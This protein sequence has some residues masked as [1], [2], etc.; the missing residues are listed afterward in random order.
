MFDLARLQEGYVITEEFVGVLRSDSMM[1]VRA[2]MREVIVFD[3][4][5]Q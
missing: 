4:Q 2:W 5:S 1:F 3:K